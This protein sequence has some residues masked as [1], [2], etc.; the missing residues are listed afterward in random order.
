MIHQLIADHA[1][2]W[3]YLASTPLSWLTLTL[4]AYVVADRISMAAGRIPP[5]IWS[6]SPA[7]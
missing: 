7:P 4:I 5:S 2:L 1:D 6:P 3:V